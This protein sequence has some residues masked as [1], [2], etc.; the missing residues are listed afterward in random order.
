MPEVLTPAEALKAESPLILTAIL[1]PVAGQDR[2]Q[3]AG[4][5]EVGHVI[6]KA[7]R[8]R[9]GAENVCIVDS[10]ASMAN[11]LESV[12]MRSAHDLDLIDHLTGMPYI[13]CVTGHR[14]KANSKRRSLLSPA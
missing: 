2:F 11:H 10:P 6:Y 8:G 7:P 14:K 5:P 3:P 1:A 13:R 4:F 9:D 12:C